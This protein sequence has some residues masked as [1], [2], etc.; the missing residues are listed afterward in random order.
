MFFDKVNLLKIC[1]NVISRNSNAA[2]EMKILQTEVEEKHTEIQ[3]L[4]NKCILDEKENKELQK[5]Y[6]K[7]SE[8][9]DN[10]YQRYEHYIYG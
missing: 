5:K 9:R 1:F 3:I 6:S 10:L 7:V 2:D 8:E 4:Q